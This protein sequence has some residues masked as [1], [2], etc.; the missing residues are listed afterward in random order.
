MDL[1]GPTRSVSLSGKKYGYVL[2][3]DFLTFTWY[4]FLNNKNKIYESCVQEKQT[5]NSF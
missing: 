2:V 1:F 5:K 4:F 3:D